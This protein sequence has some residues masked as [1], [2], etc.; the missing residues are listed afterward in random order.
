MRLAQTAMVLIAAVTLT[1]A[2]PPTRSA[3]P[4][5]AGLWEKAGEPGEPP[6]GW[7]LFVERG[8]VFEGVI[9]R[10]LPRPDDP[11]QMICSKCTDDRKDAPLLGLTFARGMKRQGLDYKDGTI[12]DPRDGAIYH[13][14]MK[15]SPDGQTLT[16]HGYVG[17]PLFGK[18]E[19]WQRLPDNMI[20]TLDPSVR[21]K[22]G[23]SPSPAGTASRAAPTARR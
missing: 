11:P 10:L 2:A 17:I 20:A 16:M 6:V 19:V 5:V 21:A 7:F 3:E 23:V 9:A 22:A 15:V 8:G 13:A 12:L 14:V 18:D 1:M 4:T